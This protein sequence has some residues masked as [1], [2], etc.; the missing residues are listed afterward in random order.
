MKMNSPT[1]ND[2]TKAVKLMRRMGA[3]LLAALLVLAMLVSTSYLFAP[4]NNQEEFGMTNAAANGV[5][6]ERSNSLDV[7]FIGDS[8]AFSS[9]SPLQMWHEW[10]FASYVCATP[11]QTLSY[12]RTLLD[13]A[14]RDQQPKVVVFETNSIY[15]PFAAS[16]AV[17]RV[18]QD[19][20]PV[21]EFHDRWK[22]S[23]DVLGIVAQASWSDE[24]K[25][26]RVNET[27]KAADAS[28]HMAPSDKKTKIP[29][30]N[31]LFIQSMVQ[32]CKDRGIAC[33]FVS[34]PSTVNW[35]TERHNGIADLARQLE[36]PYVDQNGGEDKV[37]VDWS[38]D[39]HDAGDHLNLRGA[40]KTSASLGAYLKK[41]YE[42][43]DHREDK[44]Y[45][46]WREASARYQD[47]IAGWRAP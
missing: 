10:G 23:G 26:F 30:F 37:D 19:V 27:V 17:M 39:T 20:F 38:T 29:L 18:V 7:L 21:F 28:R 9:F 8:E 4:K 25:G 11:G 5:M 33:L 44:A 35:N 22:S 24:L 13:R 40:S 36:V 6:G 12:G 15:A 46:S 3:V 34:T 31:R 2:K 42:L 32:T 14:L 1:L 41:L 47:K 45:V 16:D 43:P